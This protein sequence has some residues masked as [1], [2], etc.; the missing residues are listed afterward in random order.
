MMKYCLFSLLILVSALITACDT[1]YGDQGYF[2]NRSNDYRTAVNGPVLR[3]PAPLS[4]EKI[5]DQYVIHLEGHTSPPSLLPPGSLAWQIANDSNRM[6]A[7]GRGTEVAI[8]A[9]TRNRSGEQSP[10][11]FE[12][13]PLRQ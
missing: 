7:S 11:G 10:R 9:P 6:Q 8:T 1:I 4:A 3:I 5:S 13:R 2:H 12:S